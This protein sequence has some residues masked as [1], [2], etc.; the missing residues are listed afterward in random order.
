MLR[1]LLPI[2]GFFVATAGAQA[3]TNPDFVGAAASPPMGP[4]PGKLFAVDA[5]PA[6]DRAG[7]F[8]KAGT[9][10][11]NSFF[12]AIDAATHTAFIPSPAGRVAL[13]NTGTLRVT[14]G[15]AT[16]PGARVAR[17]L[18]GPR[19]LAVLS[20]K[21]IAFYRLSGHALVFG[22]PVGGNALAASADGKTVYVGGNM[23]SSVT[24]IDLAARSPVASWPVAHS[25]DLIRAGTHLFSADMRTGVMSVIDLADNSIVRLKTP[26]VDP[27]FSYRKIPAATAGFMQLARSPDGATVYAA[28]FSGNILKFDAAKPAYLGETRVAAGTGPEKLSGLAVAA[29]G[30]EALVTIENRDESAIVSLATGKVLRVFPGVSANRWTAAQ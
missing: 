24:A 13:V 25:G 26:E 28:G 22:L 17:V 30:N 10:A 20:A 18:P 27:R 3:A 1:K 16:I 4:G 2:L 6:S 21:E 23:D 7:A 5:A 15:F 9:P 19:L 12:A 14:G 8:A 11:G 29:S